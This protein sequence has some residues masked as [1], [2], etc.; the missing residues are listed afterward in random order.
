MSRVAKNPIS[1]SD[2]V[3][4]NITNDL[5]MVKGPNGELSVP[6]HKEVTVKFADN[7]LSVSYEDGAKAKALG[8]TTRALLANAVL[9]VTEGFDIRLQLVGVGY[10]ASLQGRNLNL[11]LGLSHPVVY[12]PPEGVTI[13]VPN[14][15][16]ILIKSAS[17]EQV[18][19]AAADIRA[20]RP[21]EP[22]KGKGIRY[23]GEVLIMKEAKKQ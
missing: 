19:Q 4:I 17:K 20:Y 1:V 13:E 6:L 15:T 23:L 11:T 22:Y 10:R 21:P 5:V 2:K 7:V 12:E 3:N 8:G 16:E 9:G 18:G 14:Q